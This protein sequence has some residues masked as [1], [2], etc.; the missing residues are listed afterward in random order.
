MLLT[1]PKLNWVRLPLQGIENCRELGGYPTKTGE[2][3]SWRTFLRSSDMSRAT[4]QDI[5]FLKEYGI[6]TVI[7]LRGE[8]E[9]KAFPNPLANESFCDYHHI[10]LFTQPLTAMNLPKNIDMGDF[11]ITLLENTTTL[12]VVFETIAEADDGSIVFHC[13]AGKD[14]TGVLAMLLLGI[15]DVAKKDIITN[16]EVTYS[17][18]ESFHDEGNI[19]PEGVPVEFLYSKREYIERAYDHL[20]E[21]YGSFEDYLQSKHI[22]RDVITKVRDRLLQKD[23]DREEVNL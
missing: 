11:Y 19:L 14:R 10:P 6:Q 18:M 17:N 23:S 21:N 3:V 15:A 20:M 2:Q 8:D 1:N 13:M 16:Y 22:S 9:V 5:A 7:D 12:P 4:E